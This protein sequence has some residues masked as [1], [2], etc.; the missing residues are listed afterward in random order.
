MEEKP[1]ISVT[2]ATYNRAH[3]LPRAVNS[4]LNQTFQDFELI[5]IDDCST[6]N[7]KEIVKSFNDKRIIYHRHE[8]N[9][10]YLAARNTGWDLARGKYNCHL[11]DDDELL[12]NALETVVNKFNELSTQG[13]KFLW[14]DIINAETGTPGGTGLKKEGYITYEYLLP[15]QPIGDYWVAFDMELLGAYRYD[16]EW[17]RAPVG[18]GI[19]WLKL[20]RR[21]RAYYVPEV[22]YKAYRE[23]G[24]ARLSNLSWIY[25][26][27]EIYLYEKTFLEENGEELKGLCS[28]KYGQKLNQFGS[29][30]ILSGEISNGRKT[31][32][33]SFKFNFSFKYFILF[34]VSFILNGNQI[35]KFYIRFFNIK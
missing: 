4:V 13:V 19:L 34:V 29:Y 6:D 2:I 11:G 14:F 28:R 30:Q 25:H 35:K 22:L 27:T 9:K 3:L 16:K 17:Y 1:I 32:I 10:G 20:H 18:D 7:T 21:S 15:A 5:I 8:K 31:L 33:S 23:H 26:F 24:S 12:P